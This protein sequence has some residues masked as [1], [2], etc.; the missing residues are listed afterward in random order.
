[1]QD[2]QSESFDYDPQ[3]SQASKTISDLKL[4]NALAYV[5]CDKLNQNSQ[6]SA[7]IWSSQKKHQI[8]KT[9]KEGGKNHKS[10]LTRFIFNLFMH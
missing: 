10:H 8:Q 4:I 3:K 7:T 2:A 9:K 6:S 5:L 1:M